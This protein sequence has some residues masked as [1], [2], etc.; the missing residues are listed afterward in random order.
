MLV[1]AVVALLAFATA[2]VG[3][4]SAALPKNLPEK[5]RSYT[6][7]GV[8]TSTFE[9]EAGVKVECTKA[10]GTGEEKAAEAAGPFHITFTECTGT[11]GIVKS[12]CTGLGDKTTGEILVLGTA[13]LVFDELTPG[14]PELKTAELFELEPVHFECA[15]GA[16]LIKVEGTELCLHLNPT[17][18]STKHEFHCV[19]AKGLNKEDTGWFNNAGEKQAF[20][21]KASVN[22]G[23]PGPAAELALSIVTTTEEVFADQ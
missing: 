11:I 9:T 19:Q 8:G 16:T 4:A 15:S 13:R 5:A 6:G 18:K 12:K 21:L 20:G 7:E 14:S 10:K 3:S 23:T 17:T 2:F 1:L 22:E